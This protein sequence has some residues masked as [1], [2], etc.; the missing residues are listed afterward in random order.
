M[1]NLAVRYHRH[2]DPLEVLL[3]EEIDLPAIG[4]GEVLIQLQAATIH[5]SD[6]GLIQGSYGKLRELPSIAGREGVGEVIEV[7]SGVDSKVKGKLVLMPEEPGV[8][9]E[10]SKSKAENLLLLPS[11]VPLN[12]LAVSAL[13]PLTAWRLLNDFEY[14]REGDF[15]IQNAANSAVGLC[16]IQ[17][18]KR[19]GVECISLVRTS[20]RIRDLEEFGADFV[21]LDDDDAVERVVERTNGKKC[22]LALNS[23]GGRS[24]LR[25]AKCLRDGGVHVTFGA[26]DGSPVRFPT[27]NLIFDDLRFVGFWLDRW[28]RKQSPAALRKTL[29]EVLQPLALAEIKHPIDQVFALTEFSQALERNGQSRMGKVLLERTKGLLAKDPRD[30]T[31]KDHP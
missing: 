3:L 14:L 16:V 15:V 12:Q 6:Y 23:V 17:F 26:M 13:N 20:A 4:E 10:Y 28:K 30:S 11:L 31:G 2:G 25:L 7:G 21:C 18:A 19:I 8:W 5:P 9:T 27:R 1:K 22:S 29:E 24:A